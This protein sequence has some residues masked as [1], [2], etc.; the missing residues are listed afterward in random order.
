LKLWRVTLNDAEIAQF[1][2]LLD[3]YEKAKGKPAA[4]VKELEK[5]LSSA[6]GKA[7]RAYDSTPDGKMNP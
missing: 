2:K 7:A 1:Q 6:A 3:L 5:W 4:T